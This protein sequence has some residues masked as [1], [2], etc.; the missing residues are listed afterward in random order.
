VRQAQIDAVAADI[1]SRALSVNAFRV[2]E[3]KD[4]TAAA[5]LLCRGELA[6]ITEKKLFGKGHN[7]LLFDGAASEHLSALSL[8]TLVLH[9]FAFAHPS[10]AL[11]IN[12]ILREFAVLLQEAHKAGCSMGLVHLNLWKPIASHIQATWKPFV[13]LKAA[14]APVLDAESLMHDGSRIVRQ[15]LRVLR[16][17]QPPQRHL[18]QPHRQQ[19]Q[20][21]HQPH[22]VTI[23]EDRRSGR[24]RER[25]SE[26]GRDRERSGERGNGRERSAERSERG[27]DRDKERE[28]GERSDERGRGRDRDRTPSRDRSRSKSEPREQPRSGTP[29][30]PGILKE[31]KQ[32]CRDF[33]A[34]ICSRGST[35]KFSH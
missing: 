32:P 16:S 10:A 30:P 23:N 33:A 13:E 22:R 35:C 21:Q 19:Q 11:Q 4:L 20:Q 27:R 31:T 8:V 15:Y 34:G 7:D 12:I 2:I 3:D 14:L 28:A 24:E 9:A 17:L 26:R 1:R 25:S 5:R 18:P 6:S 29:V